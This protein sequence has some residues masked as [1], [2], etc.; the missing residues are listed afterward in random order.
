MTAE[1]YIAG[2]LVADTALSALVGNRIYPD[3]AAQDTLRPFLLYLRTGTE[4]VAL[5]EGA[6]GE[7]LA[8]MT[9]EIYGATRAQVDQVYQAVRD[10][11]LSAGESIDTAAATYDQELDLPGMSLT[12]TVFIE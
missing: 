2:L 11:L 5:L 1:S 3:A 12:T 4:S 9:L 10:A 6:T 7:E 8:T